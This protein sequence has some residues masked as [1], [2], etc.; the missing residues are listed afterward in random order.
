MRR[1]IEIYHVEFEMFES[2]HVDKQIALKSLTQGEGQSPRYRF[3]NHQDMGD[4]Q[5]QENAS[6]ENHLMREWKEV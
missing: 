3:G 2:I 6:N 4:N 5:N 1:V